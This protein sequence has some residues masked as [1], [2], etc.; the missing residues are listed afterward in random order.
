MLYLSIHADSQ[1]QVPEDLQ[2]ILNDS[3]VFAPNT[4]ITTKEILKR[5]DNVNMIPQ[6]TVVPSSAPGSDQFSGKTANPSPMVQRVDSDGQ[7]WQNESSVRHVGG[8][9]GSGPLTY[10]PSSTHNTPPQQN[11]QLSQPT[12]P[13]AHPN[14][15]GSGDVNGSP[16]RQSGYRSS[17][18][19]RPGPM[20]VSA[21]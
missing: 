2:N 16:N 10:G 1:M 19:H 5:L 8:P 12:T 15:N 21:P 20:G 7:M 4:D 17:G 3:S 14:S 11:Y 13:Y 18:F 9:T 6:A